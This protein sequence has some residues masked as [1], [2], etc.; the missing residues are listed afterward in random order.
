MATANHVA[1]YLIKLRNTDQETGGFFSLSN[2]KLQKILYYCQGGHYQR[3]GQVLINDENFEAW[4]Y[5]PVLPSI[6]RRFTQYGRNIIPESEAK[7]F[8]LNEDEAH[9]IQLVW[10]QLK[11]LDAYVL[12]EATHNEKPWKEAI[13]NEEKMV[14]NEKIRSFFVEGI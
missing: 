8:D 13:A 10:E 6:Y 3:T 12:V 1:D 2:L 14:D 5:G 4:A 11:N 7:N 9:T